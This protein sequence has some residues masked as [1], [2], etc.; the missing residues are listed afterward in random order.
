MERVLDNRTR[1]ITVGLDDIY[2]P[3]NASAVLRTCDCFGIQDVHIIEN[4]NTYSVNPDVALGSSQW[5]E[6]IRHNQSEENTLSAVTSLRNAGYRII[7][8]TPAGKQSANPDNLNLEKGRMALFFG[9]EMEGLSAAVLD[10]ADELLTI[11]MVGFTESFNI[12]VS[13]AIILYQLTGRLRTS[14]LKWQLSEKERAK[15]KLKWL[16]ESVRGSEL[17]EKKFLENQ[18]RS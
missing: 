15:I 14:S 3:H 11:P 17:L 2:Q 5:L 8:T 16:R 1:Y 10:N 13:V 7:A 12:S 18:A 9:S 6:F 4:R